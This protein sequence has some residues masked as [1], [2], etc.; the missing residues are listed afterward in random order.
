MNE[1]ITRE[2][3]K[4][5]WFSNP[6][7]I[8]TAVIGLCLLAGLSYF[9]VVVILPFLVT[10]IWNTLAF[11]IGAVV[12]VVL[13]MV[14]F[15]PK[16]W[17]AVNYFS[18]FIAKAT[19]GWVIEMNEF[20]IFEA[21]IEQAEKDRDK[22]LTQGNKIKGKRNELAAKIAEKNKYLFDNKTRVEV[23][24]ERKK[25]GDKAIKDEE[26]GLYANNVNRANNY[27]R[28]LQPIHDE[29][30]NIEKF[31]E[32]AYDS[33]GIKLQDARNELEM[34]K[35]KYETITTGLSVAKAAWKAL[36]GN[37]NLNQDAEKAKESLRK[38]IA[39]NMAEMKTTIKYTNQIIN[40][41]ELDN[42]ISARQGINIVKQLN[43]ELEAGQQPVPI[44]LGNI[45][46]TPVDN[47]F[48][49]LLD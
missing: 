2:S 42:I 6:K 43:G 25:K 4:Q 20:N 5:S 40:G 32:T 17:R 46:V 33:S 44:S 8:G 47:K 48:K 21:Q 10:V 1:L 41:I 37:D 27:I 49:G 30:A 19:L 36:N 39:N 38:K 3:G 12:L 28:D 23:L 35:D 34:S 13:A 18:E 29:L 7:N 14:I 16:F 9:F 22:L 26:I 24:S 31:C 15:N 11:A 45:N